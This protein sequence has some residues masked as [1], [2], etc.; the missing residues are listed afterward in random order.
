MSRP[1]PELRHKLDVLRKHCDDAGRDFDSIRKTIS[2]ATFIDR[3]HSKAVERVEAS[4]RAG[5]TAVAGDPSAVRDQY[6]ELREMGFDLVVTFFE[7]FQD[8]S[9]MKLFMDE[10]I[11]EFS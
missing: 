10:V 8:L 2:I 5:Q 3:S 7:D 6:E 1:L 4:G 9:A 11:P